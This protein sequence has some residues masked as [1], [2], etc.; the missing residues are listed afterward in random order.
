MRLASSWMVMVSGIVTSRTSFSFGSS[1]ACPFSRCTRRRNAATDRSRSSS[2]LS[3]VTTVRRPRFFCPA[4]RAG[5]LFLVGLERRPCAGPSRRYGVLAETFLRLLLGL[6]LGFEL[7]LATPL[8]VGFARFGGLALSPLGG[9][10]QGA[11]KCFLL[12]NLAL[13]RFAQPSVVERVDARLLLFFGQAAQHHA[14]GR[15]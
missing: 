9:F 4:P 1:A 13:F 14:A 6:E 7:V 2:A 3:A 11:D 8:F 10:T 15:L 12:R 5:D